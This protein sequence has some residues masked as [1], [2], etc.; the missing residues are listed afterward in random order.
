V[1]HKNLKQKLNHSTKAI[2]PI[3]A[4]LM[5]MVVALAGGLVVYAWVMGYLDFTTAN[6]GKAIKIQSIGYNSTDSSLK[7]YVQNIGDGVVSIE[8]TQCLFVNGKITD[9][10]ADMV[11]IEEDDI[12]T[13]SWYPQQD[14]VDNQIIQGELIQLRVISIDGSFDTASWSYNNQ[15]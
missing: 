13:I 15:I 2:S 3:M 6:A 5:I 14:F 9:A 8:Q 4:I 12:S 11:Q 1:H 10:S 7:V